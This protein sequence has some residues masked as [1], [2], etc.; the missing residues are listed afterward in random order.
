MRRGK[1]RGWG[2]AILVIVAAGIMY[3]IATPQQIPG[4]VDVAGLRQEAQR[5]AIQGGW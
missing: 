5:R 1:R 2:R 3:H 4:K